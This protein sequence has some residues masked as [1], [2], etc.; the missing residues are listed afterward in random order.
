MYY[1]TECSMFVGKETSNILLDFLIEENFYSIVEV[2]NLISKEE[3]KEKLILVKDDIFRLDKLNLNAINERIDYYFSD[4]IT[5]NKFSLCIFLNID[6]LIYLITRGEGEVLVFRKDKLSKI[7]RGNTFASGYAKDNDIYILVSGSFKDKFNVYSLEEHLKKLDLKKT[8]EEIASNLKQKDSDESLAIFI[9]FKKNNIEE[10]NLISDLV[11]NKKNLLT[12]FINEFNFYQ[13]NFSNKK[14]ITF[15]VLLIILIIFIWSVG[16]GY[17]RRQASDNIKKIDITNKKIDNYLSEAKNT[18]LFDSLKTSQLIENSKK[19]LEDLKK[20]LNGNNQNEIDKLAEKIS[21]FEKNILK[22]E[23]KN[24]EIY[25]DFSLIRKNIKIDKI[26]Y[27]DNNSLLAFNK[28]DGEIYEISIE[29]KAVKTFKNTLF[30]SATFVGKID[31]E[32]LFFNFENGISKLTKDNQIVEVIKKDPSWGSIVEMFIY[33]KNIYLFDNGLSDIYKYTAIDGGYSD[34]KTYFADNDG[35]NFSNANSFSIDG[36]IYF[37]YSDSIVKY[38]SGLRDGFSFSSPDEHFLI[39]KIFTSKELDYFYL[40]DKKSNRV[41][42][43]KKDGK[44]EKQINSLIF[45]KAVNFFVSENVHGIFVL[46]D[47]KIYKVGLD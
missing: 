6:G 3:I 36:S 39:D 28:Q 5:K 41:L 16:F 32:I 44:Y 14:K 27:L 45:E 7:I 2:E 23:S 22:K 25:Y 34:K 30:K 42:I 24:Y 46:F 17:S 47:D 10:E 12:N 9:H 20:I 21:V 37:G 1:K 26:I 11:D 18:I 40:L 13:K 15:I 33:G 31:D 19:E 8:I 38:T 29:S 4:L 43:L 35:S